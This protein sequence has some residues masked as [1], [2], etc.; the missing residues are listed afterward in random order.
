MLPRLRE[1][2]QRAHKMGVT[3]VAGTDTTYGPT[4]LTRIGHELSHFVE[5][6]LTPLEAI[7]AATIR[8]AEMLRLEKSIGLLETSYE[9]DLI[10]TEK[11]PLEDIT[12]IKIRCW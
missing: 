3:V 9:A 4:N 12:A 7:Q 8:N 6:G 2:V 1:T 5:M 11:N 10:A